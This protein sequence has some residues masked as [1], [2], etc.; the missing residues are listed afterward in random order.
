VPDLSP[1]VLKLQVLT[2]VWMIVE[3]MGIETRVRNLG[4]L[5]IPIPFFSERQ[6]AASLSF[7]AHAVRPNRTDA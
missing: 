7:S 2:L 6:A 1:R 5:N 3:A 4:S